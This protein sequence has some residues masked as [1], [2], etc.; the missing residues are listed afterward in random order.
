MWQWRSERRKE[1]NAFAFPHSK[2][3]RLMKQLLYL[4]GLMLLVNRPL[5]AEDALIS[6]STRLQ[7]LGGVYSSLPDNIEL[8]SL[9]PA[10]L[11]FVEDSKLTLFNL[12]LELNGDAFST[13]KDFIDAYQDAK[14]TKDL[15]PK[16]IQRLE[17]HD[18]LFGVFGPFQISYV[19]KHWGL[20]LSNLKAQFSPRFSYDADASTVRLDG[21]GDT[22]LA[23]AY[24]LRVKR[25]LSAGISLKYQV[26]AQLLDTDVAEI[27]ETDLL[28]L[29]YG[30]GFDLGLFYPVQHFLSHPLYL[31]VT[32]H[33][34]FDGTLN[35][36][37]FHL[38]RK[39]S[40]KGEAKEIA[41]QFRLGVTY[42]PDF[43]I[44]YQGW[45]YFPLRT[46]LS[47]EVGSG[48]S[49]G[50][51]LHLGAEVQLRHWLALRLGVNRGIRLGFGLNTQTFFLDY[52]YS[53][54]MEAH[55][56]VHSISMMRRF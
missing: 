4:M 28:F 52:M 11:S 53:P 42:Q 7:N 27:T 46:L 25:G 49:F 39:G 54:R 29:R 43:K 31:G 34:V 2:G 50:E 5:F 48:D 6:Q 10:V 19:K 17:R 8:L 3:N 45:V 32:Y 38:D 13:V 15:S 47:I 12:R 30:L 35:E 18:P 23:F 40:T 51:R 44:P 41:R 24:G 9:N 20:S 37:E 26:R 56:G 33:D 55:R 1:Q 16:A 22:V 21:H 36:R 14:T